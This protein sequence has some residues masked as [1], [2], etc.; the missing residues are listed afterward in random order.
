MK[1]VAIN[2]ADA[3][4]PESGKTYRQENNAKKHNIPH[5][6]LVEVDFD[7]T[8]NDR[9]H[10]GLRLFVVSLDRDCDGTPLYGLSFDKNW[11]QDMYGI[12]FKHMANSRVDRGYSEETLKVIQ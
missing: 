3:V 6:S 9:P 7:D 10:K 2:I 12:Q 11:S 5:G 8:Y 4:N 1:V